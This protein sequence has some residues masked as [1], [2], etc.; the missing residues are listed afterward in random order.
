[1]THLLR[2]NSQIPAYMAYTSFAVSLMS[3]VSKNLGYAIY[4]G[5]WLSLRIFLV[6]RSPP[7]P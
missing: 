1:M 6:M 3:I 4:A 7:I 2:K 5:I